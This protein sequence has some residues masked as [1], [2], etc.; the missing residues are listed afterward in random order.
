VEESETRERNQ[1]LSDENGADGVAPGPAVM[2]IAAAGGSSGSVF[3]DDEHVDLPDDPDVVRT[4]L[5]S[6]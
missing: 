6:V 3:P 4:S 5:K 2:R 1:E